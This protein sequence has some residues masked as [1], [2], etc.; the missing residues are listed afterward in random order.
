MF[1]IFLNRAA[2]LSSSIYIFLPC[3]VIDKPT[4]REN[5]R[6]FQT[7]SKL[8]VTFVLHFSGSS[9]HLHRNNLAP[10]YMQWA[11]RNRESNTRTAGLRVTGGSNLVFIDPASLRRTTATSAVATAQEPITMGTTASCLARAFGIVIRQIADL[12]V[13][14]QDY[15][16]QAP[17]LPRLM[18]I[19][20]QDALN[21]QVYKSIVVRCCWVAYD[22]RA[23]TN[24]LCRSHI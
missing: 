7:R 14:M 6:S 23:L 16:T 2:V 24:H 11:I 12:L 22:R 4:K 20:F 19:T 9:G 15:K 18:E 3:Y 10:V 1:S 17:A 5:T 8:N 13:L 21:L